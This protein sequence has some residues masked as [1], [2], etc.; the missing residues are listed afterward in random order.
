MSNR[1]FSTLAL[2]SLTSGKLLSAFADMHEAAE[3]VLGHPVWT[4]E[5]ASRETWDRLR[6]TVLAQHP[7]LDVD[8]ASVDHHNVATFTAALVKRMGETREVKRGSE[9]RTASPVDTL[10]DVAGGLGR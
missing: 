2:V 6:A 3:H 4:H 1:T 9:R 5:F 7:D 10:G 8:C